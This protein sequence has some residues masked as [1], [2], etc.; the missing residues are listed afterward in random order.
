MSSDPD[1]GLSELSLEPV[2]KPKQI[3]S[4]GQWLRAFNTFVAVY[5]VS[6]AVSAP[7]LMKY[8]E[9]VRDLANKQGH[10]R[11]YDEQFRFLRQSKPKLLFRRDQVYWEL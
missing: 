1:N 4:I 11:W 10:W 8:C 7:A 2:Q 9:I 5:K 3:E 6:F